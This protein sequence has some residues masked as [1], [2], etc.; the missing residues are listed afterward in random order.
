MT[1]CSASVSSRAPTRSA[2]QRTLLCVGTNN[3]EVTDVGGAQV[4]AQ[5]PIEPLNRDGNRAQCRKLPIPEPTVI[6]DEDDSR[7]QRERQRRC[8][9]QAHTRQ[10]SLQQCPERAQI[11]DRKSQRQ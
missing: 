2:P 5:G 11:G 9:G 3:D 8:E 7:E 6:G 4:G 1:P 10:S